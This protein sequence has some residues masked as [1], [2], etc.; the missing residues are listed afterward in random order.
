MSRYADIV[1]PLAQP[2]YSYAIADG[3]E[4]ECGDAVAVQLHGGSLVQH[5]LLLVGDDLRELDPLHVQSLGLLGDVQ[6]I[7]EG[8][9]GVVPLRHEA[10]GEV[11]LKFLG[12]QVLGGSSAGHTLDGVTITFK[13]GDAAMGTDIQYPLYVLSALLMLSMLF[14]SM[15]N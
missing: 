2:A 8:L 4:L 9:L 10:V 5:H 12:G 6:P 11:T 13:M 15:L 3:L 1:L 14:A 7:D